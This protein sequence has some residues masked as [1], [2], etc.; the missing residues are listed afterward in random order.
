MVTWIDG[1]EKWMQD[2]IGVSD[3]LEV[4]G[5]GQIRTRDQLDRMKHVR[6]SEK[7]KVF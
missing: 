6:T 4:E 3:E 2:W 1:L 5:D 7:K